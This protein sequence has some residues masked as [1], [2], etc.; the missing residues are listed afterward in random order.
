MLS[1]TLR[2]NFRYLMI[3]HTLHPLYQPR[4]TMEHILK[5]KQMYEK[6]VNK[7]MCVC[8]HKVTQ[9][10]IMKIKMKIKKA[11]HRCDINRH[12]H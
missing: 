4:K 10:I 5:N 1:K 3:I 2:L 9:L 11:L 8:T 7:N 12:R 6:K